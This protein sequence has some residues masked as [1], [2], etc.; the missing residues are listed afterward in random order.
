MGRYAEPV[1]LQAIKRYVMRGAP[2]KPK[3]LWKLEIS[4]WAPR[5]KWA[6]SRDFWDT[7]AVERRMFEKD[8]ERVRLRDSSSNPRGHVLARRPRLKGFAAPLSLARVAG[9]RVRPRAV[10]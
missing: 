1:E 10:Y 9:H 6:D 2:P 3:K 7:E 5:T 4:I 8:W